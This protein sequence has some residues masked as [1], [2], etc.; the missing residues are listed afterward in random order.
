[1]SFVNIIS[2][3]GNNN[4][5]YPLIVR[6]CGLE[7]TA[8]V[9]MTYRQNAPDSKFIAKQAARERIIDE[10]GTSVIWLF[11]IPLI[12]RL[13]NK[14][15]KKQSFCPFVSSKLFKE[16]DAQGLEFNI[17]KFKNTAPDAVKDL[18]KIQ[19]NKKAYQTLLSKKFLAATIIPI[20][21]MGYALPKMN[22]A[23][24]KKKIEQSKKECPQK[25]SF[26]GLEKLSELSTLQK[27]M[28]LDGGLSA[29]RIQTARNK[30]E[31]LEMAFKMTGMFYLNFFAPKTID[32]VLNFLTKQTFGINTSL[33]PKILN[34]SKFL[35]AIKNKSLELPSNISEKGL[36]EFI[37]QN[38]TAIFTKIAQKLKIVSFL[39]NNVRDPRRYVDSEVLLKL[40]N[41]I[42]EFSKDA[43]KSS[44]VDLFA[45]KALRAKSLNILAN[46]TLSST[47]LAVVLPKAQFIFRKLLTGSNL[48]PGINIKSN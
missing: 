38:P 20:A 44:N 47:L 48:E 9:F 33:D 42:E 7:N 8:K 5:I 18:I 37:D 35:S 22:F 24:T 13:Y 39:N 21:L 23:Y 46:I 43:L 32:K 30:N 31:K 1:M 26:K 19:K 6:D 17:N 45:K 12:E 27:M 4:S 25:V 16:S 15:I 40:K 28:I 29:G 41:S 34:D 11:G 2:A 36:I 10:Y 14:I 3:L